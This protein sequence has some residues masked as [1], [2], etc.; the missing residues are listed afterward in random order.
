VS[1]ASSGCGGAGG[2]GGG[3]GSGGGS[4]EFAGEVVGR[5]MEIDKPLSIVFVCEL[6]PRTRG[7][8]GAQRKCVTSPFS[9]IIIFFKLFFF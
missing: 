5:E 3:A 2:G 9:P 4:M 1:V 7:S 6:N 8:S